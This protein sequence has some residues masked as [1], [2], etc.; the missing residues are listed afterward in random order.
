MQSNLI[1]LESLFL[2]IQGFR[3]GCILSPLLF[4]LFLNEL[5]LSLNNDITN[6]IILPSGE[7]INIL[8]YADDLLFISRSK[9][10]L[11]SCLDHLQSFCSTW[12]KEVNLKK[13]KI[14][15]F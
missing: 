6:P 13:T 7:K 4:N 11:Q 8:F 14:M 9:V 5:L 3:Q 10:G 15:I 2:N 12:H 1:T